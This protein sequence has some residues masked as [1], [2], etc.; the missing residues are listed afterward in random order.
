[1]YQHLE[2]YIQIAKLDVKHNKKEISAF[3]IL[4]IFNI[5]FLIVDFV[6]GLHGSMVACMGAGAMLMSSFYS[7]FMLIDTIAN[8][9]ESKRFLL[10]Y[11]EMLDRKNI[12][13]LNEHA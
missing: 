8:Y 5:C 11:K 13:E 1:M 4:T 3:F 2:I 12:T 10:F 6:N 7:S 9:K